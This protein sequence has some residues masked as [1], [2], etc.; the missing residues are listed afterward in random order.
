MGRTF[1]RL[2][3]NYYER[4]I[5][6]SKSSGAV[7]VG[8]FIFGSQIFC[9]NLGDC[10]AVLSSNGKAIDLS[11]DHKACLL[12]EINRVKMRG[13]FVVGG[14]VAGRLAVARAFGDHELKV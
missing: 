6:V 3:Q 13:G 5:E 12:S 11:Q 2:D 8:C 4:F 9:I 1:K 10:R 7:A 14:R